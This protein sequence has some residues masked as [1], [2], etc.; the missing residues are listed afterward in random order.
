MRML[1]RFQ[2]EADMNLPINRALPY[3]E[4]CWTSNF[5][6]LL[7]NTQERKRLNYSDSQ[8]VYQISLAEELKEKA[9][10]ESSL[11]SRVKYGTICLMLRYFNGEKCAAEIYDQL[12]AYEESLPHNRVTVWEEYDDETID[13]F[14]LILRSLCILA[15][16]RSECADGV[17]KVFEHLLDIY[18]HFPS[19]N[20]LECIADGFIYLYLIPTMKYLNKERRLPAL[21]QLT[22]YRQPQTLFHTVMVARCA[23]LVIREIVHRYPEKLTGVL[24]CK[25]AEE[26]K[27][28]EN[29]LAEFVEN[30]ALLHDLGKILCTNVVNMQYRK[31]NDI[32]FQVIQY[33]PETSLRI[34]NSIPSLAK[35]ADVAAGHHK[36]SDGAFGYPKEFDIFSASDIILI[37]LVRIC[38]SLDAATDYLGRSYA[39]SKTF[40]Q[41]LAELQK[42]SGTCYSKEIIN[43]ITESDSLQK[44]LEKLLLYDRETICLEMYQVM[45]GRIQ[46]KQ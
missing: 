41:V 24:F 4:N 35:Y 45:K 21:L 44:Q 13:S 30:S 38:D 46:W 34:L 9:E 28:R 22:V 6:R 1:R 32:E 2:K 7:I 3:F 43:V 26:V 39:R 15:E 19:N 23:K 5:L 40:A 17:K 18:T 27:K 31:L 29:E 8:L 42:G 36:T 37:D 14:N 16:D 20:Y 10:C 33:H 11:V 12:M 25:T